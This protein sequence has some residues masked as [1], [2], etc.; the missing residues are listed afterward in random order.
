MSTHR[1]HGL[2]PA[3][4]A[5]TVPQLR[6]YI[7]DAE[8]GVRSLTATATSLGISRQSLSAA[9]RRAGLRLRTSQQVAAQ[10]LLQH[11][12]TSVSGLVHAMPGWSRTRAERALH[13]LHAQGHL[14]RAGTLPTL[15]RRPH[16]RNPPL[17]P[18]QLWELTPAGRHHHTQEAPHD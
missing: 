8:L 18:S 13:R 12:P 17:R 6:R 15:P 9:V 2:A 1:R 10:H 16:Q 11:G 7:S 14:Q 5:Y 4:S 3:A